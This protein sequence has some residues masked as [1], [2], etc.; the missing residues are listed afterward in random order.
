MFVLLLL[1]LIFLFP[2]CLL[3]SAA[4]VVGFNFANSNKAV[5]QRWRRRRS[6]LMHNKATRK[7]RSGLYL[8]I[9]TLLTYSLIN[10]RSLRGLC[11]NTCE[12]KTTPNILYFF[13][14]RSHSLDERLL[15]CS[16]VEVRQVRF[17]PG[18]INDTHI[19]V[20]TS[21]N[22]LRYLTQ[23]ELFDLLLF[24]LDFTTWTIRLPKGSMCTNLEGN[25][26]VLSVLRTGHFWR[27]WETP[28]SISISVHRK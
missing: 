20:L 27:L 13:L 26:W 2:S 16:H 3:Y 21:D 9:K 25:L 24:V 17:H 19:V 28:Q 12:A 18:S 22:V 23:F 10:P 14:S 15:A 7:L 11:G 8:V 6:R 4:V 5:Y 1:L